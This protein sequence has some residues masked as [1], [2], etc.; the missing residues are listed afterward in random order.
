MTGRRP[1]VILGAGGHGRVS[2]EVAAAA[3]IE[4]AGFLDAAMEPGREVNGRPVLGADMAALAPSHSPSTTGLF[5][6]IGDNARRMALAREAE[7]AGY[8]LATLIHPAAVISPTARIGRGSIVMAGVVIN[9]N[10]EIGR[11]CIVNTG[12]TLDHDDHLEEA[13][14]ICPGVHVAGTVR[15]GAA[16]FVGTGAAIVPGVR[17]GAGAVV[18]AGA[19]VTADVPDGARV[20]GTPARPMT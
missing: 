16:A 5:I 18:A 14:Q 4:V 12:A 3:G 11:L 13:V 10:A 2:A 20:A 19:T 7:A 6:A 1:L 17:I 9:A 15:F 8:S